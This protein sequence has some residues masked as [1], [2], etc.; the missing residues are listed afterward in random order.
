[1]ALRF[2]NLDPRADKNDRYRTGKGFTIPAPFNA[3]DLD[4][5]SGGELHIA[6]G[7]L[8]AFTLHLYGLRV[9]GLP[10][11]GT[12]TPWLA[13]LADVGRLVTWYDD[14]E[15]GA[16]GRR[17]FAAALVKTLGRA[18]VAER[19]RAVTLH[20]DDVNGCHQRGALAD[21]ITRAEWRTA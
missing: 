3:D 9:V 10:G 5:S 8:D 21:L 17:E 2:R 13:E 14:D 19:G 11:A 16:K 12:A 18:W 15:G 20:A 7:E 4:D 1:M 6:E